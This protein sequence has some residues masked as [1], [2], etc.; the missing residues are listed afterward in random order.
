M[1]NL[2]TFKDNVAQIPKG[3]NPKAAQYLAN[4]QAFPFTSIIFF[5]RIPE[6]DGT[7]FLIYK[8]SHMWYNVL[9]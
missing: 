5:G 4:P 6:A 2:I 7:N 3:T 9:R 8:Q 1:L